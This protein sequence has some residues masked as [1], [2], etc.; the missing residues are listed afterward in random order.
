MRKLY[1]EFFYIPKHGKVR[2]KVMF[3]R[4]VSMIAIVIMCL[5]AISF[6]AYAYFSYNITSGSNIIKAAN[7]EA[8]VSVIANSSSDPIMVTKDGKIQTVTLSAGT[9]TVKLT[10]GD[11][12]ADTGFCIVTIG[13][14]TFFT[15]QI[16]KDVAKNLT[17]ASVTFTLKVPV[18]TKITFLSHWGTSSFY[19]YEKH[20]SNP[21]YIE[22]QNE[23][24]PTI[25][26]NGVNES[27]P[28]E[29]QGATNETTIPSEVIHT[30][31]AGE[32]LSAIA[33]KYGVYAE[34]IAIY[35]EITD[36]N[37]I[38][39]GQRLKIP[40]ADYE[41][42]A[43]TAEQTTTVPNTAQQIETTERAQ[44]IT[45]NLETIGAIT[46]EANE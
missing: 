46:T 32:T 7:F 35:N 31:V 41:V 1:D 16:G 38:Y 24:D 30:V 22:D 44:L 39:E 17:D 36:K 3:T 8:S 2:E 18:E 34:Q 15:A 28:D 33:A 25:A 21:L 9:Y 23:I 42:P 4:M 20:D 10:A 5:A 43:G 6:S 13:K 11:S 12:T 29:E 19:G 14:D 27:S 37:I 45:E 26:M 40:P